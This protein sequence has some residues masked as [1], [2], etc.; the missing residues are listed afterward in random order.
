MGK[1]TNAPTKAYLDLLES[2]KNESPYEKNKVAA[3]G[4]VDVLSGNR[5]LGQQMVYGV[6]GII[7]F[8]MPPDMSH[9][10]FK[11]YN[12]TQADRE[13]LSK[14]RHFLTHAEEDV[15]LTILRDKNLSISGYHRFFVSRWPCAT[16]ARL[17]IN[18]G[19]KH[20]V[21][22]E[23]VGPEEGSKW[24]EEHKASERL[25]EIYDIKVTRL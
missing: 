10:D 9:A 14:N 3:L 5:L 6:N 4:E 2:L 24:Y 7:R 15:I 1:I 18:A 17:I 19:Y 23:D 22:R 13:E 20:L 16:C 25:F 8:V 21:V 11:K 12:L